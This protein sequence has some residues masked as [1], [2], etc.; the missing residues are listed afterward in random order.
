MK[1]PEKLKENQYQKRSWCGD[2]SHMMIDHL[3]R[4]KRSMDAQKSKQILIHHMIP[5]SKDLFGNENFI[6]Q[7]DND[8]KHTAKIVQSHLQTKEIQVIDHPPQSPDL[9]P[10]ENLCAFF[11]SNLKDRNPK[12]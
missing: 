2:A 8:A 10:I 11:D 5:S 3:H 1:L 6:F 7:H 9:N 12:T 4:V